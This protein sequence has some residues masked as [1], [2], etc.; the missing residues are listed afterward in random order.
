MTLI[1][2]VI[3]YF[4]WWC[5]SRLMTLYFLKNVLYRD[6]YKKSWTPFYGEVFIL[7]AVVWV[8]GIVALAF[9]HE[10]FKKNCLHKKSSDV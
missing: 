6:Q 4:V 10:V 2:L 5:V 1:E 7:A 3:W 8:I 9:Y